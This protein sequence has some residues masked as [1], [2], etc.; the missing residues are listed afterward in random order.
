MNKL[1]NIIVVNAG[2]NTNENILIGKISQHITKYYD[3]KVNDVD[4]I[5]EGA[6]ELEKIR[7]FAEI[8]LNI[9]NFPKLNSSIF[10]KNKM[11]MVN[12]NKDELIN[13]DAD[14]ADVVDDADDTNVV[15]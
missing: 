12:E 11:D 1:R 2:E 15:S 14:V 3:L 6:Q 5:L 7:R 13:D 8:R 4:K 10:I 9:K